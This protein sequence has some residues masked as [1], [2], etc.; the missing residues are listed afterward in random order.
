METSHTVLSVMGFGGAWLSLV[1]AVIQY[2]RITSAA[3]D[4]LRVI[5]CD[6]GALP[7]RLLD[8][9]APALS[10]EPRGT[11]PSEGEKPTDKDEYVYFGGLSEAQRL[12]SYALQDMI[13]EATGTRVDKPG[14][15][16]YLKA[17]RQVDERTLAELAEWTISPEELLKRANDN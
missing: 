10:P 17:I 8:A 13:A 7:G 4:A 9:E 5:G 3:S 1:G 2:Y 15:H 16:P 11:I 14:L 6:G 12:A